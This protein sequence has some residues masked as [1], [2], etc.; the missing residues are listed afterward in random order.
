MEKLS[1]KTGVQRNEIQKKFD[2]VEK[3][4][5][6]VQIAEDK[7]V[8]V[9]LVNVEPLIVFMFFPAIL[10]GKQAWEART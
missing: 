4:V 8:G 9:I 2:A 6:A 1:N 3:A 5:R 7:L 10:R